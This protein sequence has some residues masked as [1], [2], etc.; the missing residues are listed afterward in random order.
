M[1]SISPVPTHPTAAAPLRGF[2][3]SNRFAA[4]ATALVIAACGGSSAPPT[5]PSVTSTPAPPS[6][7]P[8]PGPASTLPASCRSLPPATG[9]AAG[10]HLEAS[11][12]LGKVAD[13]VS[14][15]QNS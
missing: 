9:T 13:A 10:C 15:A 12:F 2:Q 11:D 4:L 3:I 14:I 1:T 5:A 6:S 7:T 8:A